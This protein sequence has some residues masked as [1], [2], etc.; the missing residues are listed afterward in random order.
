MVSNRPNKLRDAV[1]A[2]RSTLIVVS[3]FMAASIIAVVIALA[4]SS[5][6]SSETPVGLREYKITMPDSTATRSGRRVVI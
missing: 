4:V 6:G 3:A 5:D 2:L 1:R